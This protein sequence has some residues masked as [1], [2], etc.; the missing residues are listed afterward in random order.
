ML[1]KGAE[2]AP[3]CFSS[4]WEQLFLGEHQSHFLF[5][6]LVCISL[7]W[8]WQQVG[9]VSFSGGAAAHAQCVSRA[10]HRARGLCSLTLSLK[11]GFV[12]LGAGG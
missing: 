2:N 10:G 8:N 1:I 6:S 11:A 9:P 7:P 3:G 4:S 5:T 12:V